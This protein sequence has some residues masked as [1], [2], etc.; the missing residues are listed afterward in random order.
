[1][2]QGFD[3]VGDI[4][5]DDDGQKYLILPMDDV[6]Y[7]AVDTTLRTLTNDQAS[8]KQP[9]FNDIT[10][11]LTA[12]NP[13][14]QTDAGVP[15]LS[16][17]AGSLSVLGIKSL[18]GNFRT[19][20]NVAE[21]LDQWTL[22]SMGDNVTVRSA[23]VPKFVNNIWKMLSPDERSQQEVSAYVQALAYNQANDLGIDPTDEKYRDENGVVNQALL[24][25]D[26]RKYLQNVKISAH[27]I[28]VTRALLG[29]IL[30]FSVQTKDT[31]DLPTYLKDTGIV[32][33][34]SSFFEVL[35]QIKLKYP[36]VENH[37][38]LALATWMGENPGKVVYVVSTDQEAVKPLIRYSTEMQ[39]W[40]IS[41]K[42]SIEKYGNGA[43]MFAPNTGEFSPGV[44]KWAEAAGITSK[45][46]ENKTVEKYIE[47]YYEDL[48]LKEYANAYYDINDQ[49]AADLLGVAFESADLRRAS[50]KAYENWRREYKMGVPGLEEYIASGTDN[51]DASEFIQSAYNYVNSP[52]ASV[53]PEVKQSINEAYQIFNEF[54]EY[55]NYIDTLDPSGGADLKRAK[56]AEAQERI[57]LLIRADTSKTVE[58]YYK[59]GLLKMMN[60]KSRDAQPGV[61]RNVIKKVGS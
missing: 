32:S 33:M 11:N 1:M 61:T 24:D 30:P 25:E 10:F 52:E 6:I 19:T 41:N 18:L 54:I 40:A 8:I 42:Q 14:F 2:N 17:P 7:S 23:I 60:A 12:G 56:K 43:L 35:D 16:G 28:I 26:K 46:P 36:D 4:H 59:Y 21:D 13:S 38:E 31:K 3:A 53:K 27:N 39:D 29:M 50:L 20:A 44:Y 57:K 9:L 58:Q 48:M 49:E 37:Y 45:I 55:A 5:T 51:G 22:G 15:Y 34:K 47:D